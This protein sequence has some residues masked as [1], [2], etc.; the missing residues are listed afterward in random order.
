MDCLRTAPSFSSA[1]SRASLTSRNPSAPPGAS[2]CSP[3][4]HP[5]LRVPG[6]AFA[7][8]PFQSDQSLTKLGEGGRFLL[9]IRLGVPQ[10]LGARGIRLPGGA[11]AN[12]PASFRAPRAL[13]SAGSATPARNPAHPRSRSDRHLATRASFAPKP[14][15][16][17]PL[18]PLHPPRSPLVAAW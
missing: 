12:S 3:A 14:P 8:L 17:P 5:L 15:R 10:R 7:R 6:N 18:A 2:S 1:W 16:L 9:G 4:P 13:S 11:F